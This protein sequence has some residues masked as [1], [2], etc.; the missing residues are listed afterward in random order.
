MLYAL[1]RRTAHAA[2]RVGFHFRAIG[3]ENVPPEGPAVLAANH[4]SF[5]DPPA[6]GAPLRRELH[7]LAKVE[8][9]RVPGLGGFLR[10]L[11]AHPVDRSGSDAAALRLAL[12]LL[13][14]GQALVLFPEGTRGHGDALRPAQAGTGM[15][16]AL[17]GAPVVPVYVQGTRQALPRG[18]VVPRASRIT[19]TYGAPLHFRRERG[20]ARYQAISDAIMAAIGRIKAGGGRVQGVPASAATELNDS[21]SATRGQ[22]AAGQIQ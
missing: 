21:A 20:R 14:E 12:R 15:L 8:L 5:F 13:T 1:M 11:N 4:T 3:L 16:V 7:F 17:S 22:L 18:A 9:F 19:V 10:R 2:L 6:V